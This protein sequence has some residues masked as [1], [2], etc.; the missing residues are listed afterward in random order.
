VA[1]NDS[2]T[3]VASLNMGSVNFG[4]QVYINTLPDIRYWAGR[5]REARVV[6]ELEIFEAG[7]LPVVEELVREGA[8]QKP[9]HYNFVLGAHWAMPADVRSLSFLT[10]LLDAAAQWGVIQDAMTDF[11]LLAAA[12]AMGTKV[13]RV[14]FE[15]SVFYAPGRAAKSNTELVDKITALI[16][17]MGFEVASADEAGE[18]L[19]VLK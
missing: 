6:P 10:S 11:S 19:G 5:M 9:F 3:Q 7:M 14:G 8:L 2:R 17:L 13:V 1:L 12:I 4:E 18:I 15:D 16:R